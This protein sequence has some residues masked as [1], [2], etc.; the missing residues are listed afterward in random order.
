MPNGM[1]LCSYHQFCM[2]FG[3]LRQSMVHFECVVLDK[4]YFGVVGCIARGNVMDELVVLTPRCRGA[5]AS[6]ASCDVLGPSGSPP[7]SSC[8]RVVWQGRP[9]KYCIIIAISPDPIKIVRTYLNIRGA[10]LLA[11]KAT[12]SF[13]GAITILKVYKGIVFNFLNAF[14]FAILLK[15][16]LLKLKEHIIKK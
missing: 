9:E 6:F 2:N 16:L 1:V 15:M 7:F 5:L 14:Y 8:P 13:D 10:D 4:F 12:H 11:I 3:I